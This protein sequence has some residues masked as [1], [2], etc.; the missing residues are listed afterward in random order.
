[1]NSVSTCKVPQHT[2]KT[3]LTT[4]P[5]HPTTSQNR[6]KICYCHSGI[7]KPRKPLDANISSELKHGQNPKEDIWNYQK[8]QSISQQ[9][10]INM[11]LYIKQLSDRNLETVKLLSLHLTK[12]Q[13]NWKKKIEKGKKVGQWY[14]ISSESEKIKQTR[15]FQPKKR[16]LN[17]S[18]SYKITN[19]GHSR[20]L[21]K[22][23]S[24]LLAHQ[25]QTT[26]SI[27][28]QLMDPAAFIL[29]GIPGHVFSSQIFRSA[30]MK[31]EIHC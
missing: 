30:Y 27:F 26:N 28:R 1:M 9:E 3:I 22:Y 7:S 21:G 2:N 5:T 15:T 11:T 8:K 29:P 17:T 13:L 24:C 16:C 12:T 10:S 6:L 14:K 23:Y 19:D 31:C 18:H 4:Y 25:S 20:R